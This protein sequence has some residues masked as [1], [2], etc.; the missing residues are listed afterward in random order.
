MAQPVPSSDDLL[1]RFRRLRRRHATLLVGVDGR[2]GSGKS[3]LA[4]RLEASE[5]LVTVVEFDDFYRPSSERKLRAARGASEIGGNFDWR[6]LREQVLQPLSRDD[7][8]HYQR[9]DWASDELAEWH[10]VPVG[11][12]VIV[13]GNYAT[14][15]ELRA[16]YDFT[17]WVDAPHELRLQRGLQRGGDD[18]LE[19]WLTEWIPEEDRYIEAENPRERVDL[20]LDGAEG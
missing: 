20:A 14:R 6:R 11:G 2:G 8:A 16:F 7:P 13:E 3:T 17:I 18:T 19:R 5:R 1:E 10:E 9:Y 12:I 15:R 4:R